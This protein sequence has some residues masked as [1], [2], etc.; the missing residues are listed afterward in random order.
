MKKILTILLL[1]IGL[2]GYTQEVKKIEI[3]LESGETK[4][5]NWINLEETPTFQKPF[6]RI[7]SLSGLKIKIKDIKSYKGYDQNGN[8]R[9]LQKI[10]LYRKGEF[11]FT[12]L[13]FRKDSTDAVKIYYNKNTF[14]FG[15]ETGNETFN[16]YQLKNKE[17]KKLNYKNVSQDFI[18]LNYSNKSLEKVKQLRILQ[19]TSLAIAS[20]FLGYYL[21]NNT[22][23][24]KGGFMD[25]NSALY[26]AAI[27]FV[28]PFTL[29][30]TKKDK[31]IEAL[32]NYK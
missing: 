12:E 30:K 25:N 29:E 19:F 9:Q 4:T 11:R 8:Y 1:F 22:S 27:F 13:M 5:T 6:L 15:F 3:I 18:D 28:L 31:L 24:S 7:D 16:Q 26:P 32:K 23:P 14:A 2:S 21:V 17:I 20:G 10:S